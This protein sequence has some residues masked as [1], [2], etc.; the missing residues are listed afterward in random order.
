MDANITIG[1]Q[2]QTAVDVELRPVSC[3]DGTVLLF[4]IYIRGRWHGSRRT[5][6][7]CIAHALHVE[8]VGEAG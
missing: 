8:R 4:D 2:A 5:H 1:G 6:A 3:V 7:Q